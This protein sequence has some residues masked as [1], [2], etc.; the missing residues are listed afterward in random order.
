MLKKLWEKLKNLFSKKDDCCKE[1]KTCC[2]EVV[3]EK[4][5][6]VVKPK[7]V[8]PK[9]TGTTGTSKPKGTTGTTGTSK[10][11]GTTGGKK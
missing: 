2:K 8:T 5:V 6:E 1:G 7:E 4:Q 11:K 10:P 3:V 9:T